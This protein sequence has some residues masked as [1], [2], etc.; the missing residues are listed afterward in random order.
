[1]PLLRSL[2]QVDGDSIN[3]ALL[4]SFHARH[5][6]PLKTAKNQIFSWSIFKGLSPINPH[7]TRLRE[8]DMW[9]ADKAVRAP[10]ARGT[11]CFSRCRGDIA[12]AFSDSMKATPCLGWYTILLFACCATIGFGETSARANTVRVAAA[13]AA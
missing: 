8:S 2:D 11:T 3:M 6:I 10:S 5:A 9:S 12:S 7:C 13:Q 4:R 1:M